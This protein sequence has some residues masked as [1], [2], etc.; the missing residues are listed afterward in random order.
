M[1][2]ALPIGLPIKHEYISPGLTHA[3]YGWLQVSFMRA[4]Q[5][6]GLFKIGGKRGRWGMG[7]GE[8]EREE[9]RVPMNSSSQAK[10][11]DP[12]RPK[13]PSAT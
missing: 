6:D 13:R 7:G 11:S 9:V 3:C 5:T 1:P 2:P 12:Q 10:R 4:K 8:R